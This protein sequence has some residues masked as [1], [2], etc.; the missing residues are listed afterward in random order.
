MAPPSVRVRDHRG[1]RDDPCDFRGYEV[2]TDDD[3]DDAVWAVGAGM[4]PP[5]APIQERHEVRGD[6]RP[7]Q[8][9]EESW[10][11]RATGGRQP[12][13]ALPGLPRRES[14]IPAPVADPPSLC[15]DV[16]QQGPHVPRWIGPDYC[17]QIRESG[18][19]MRDHAGEP[20]Q[21][22]GAAMRDHAGEPGRG[23]GAAKRDHAGE[24]GRGS[25]AAK[26]DHAG[27]PGRGSGAAKRDHAGEPGRGSGA[28]KRDHAGE[29]GRGSGAAKRDHAGEPGRG[30][31]AA[32]R[33]HAGEPGRGS[34]AA[35]RDHAGEP[36]RGSGAATPDHAGE[37]A[38]GTGAATPDHAGEPARGTGAAT[39]DHAGEPARGTGA[40]TP[41]HAG[42]PARGTGPPFVPGMPPPQVPASP[43]YVP[44]MPP[45][46][47]PASPPYVPG[48]P[49][50]QVPAS[51]PYVPGMPPPQVPASPPY[52]PVMPQVPAS[53]PFVPGM[54]PPQA[55]ASPPPAP[56][57]QGTVGQLQDSGSV[58][59]QLLGPVKELTWKY[60]EMPVE[61]TSPPVQFQLR[62]PVSV[63]SVA[64]TC[65]ENMV[66]VQV[67]KDLF[68]SGE[69]IRASDISLGGC[70]VT[71][72]DSVAQLLYFQ[73]YLQACGSQV[74][75]NDTLVYSFSLTYLPTAAS[76]T[77]API[78]RTSGAVIG[79]EC[80]YLRLHNVSSNALQPAWIPYAATKIAQELL[81]FSLKLMTEAFQRVL[82][83]RSHP[84]EASVKQYN[85][86]PLR[87]FVDSCQVT[88]YPYAV[89]LNFL[90]AHWLLL[91]LLPRTQ[92]F[93]LQFQLEAFRFQQGDTGSLY[94]TCVLKAT[95][96]ASPTD[97]EHK[98]C[99][100][101]GQKWAGAGGEDQ[102]CSCCDGTCGSRKAR[103]L[104]S[105]SGM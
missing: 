45:P 15:P 39:P 11:K 97:A 22:S 70:G 95:A 62:E 54:P 74:M 81:V 63:S 75:T 98:A 65:D 82:H 24:P 69:L 18:A 8:Q 55:P 92:D 16:P 105:V 57:P 83:G 29:P 104:T 72:E 6:P 101:V 12:A 80:H 27:E 88:P 99:S 42:E 102:L 94:I 61:P 76:N 40:A 25:G 34:G 96:A 13:T 89:Q 23:S 73:S 58:Q 46:Q 5:I 66:H 9:C 38:R 20:G 84:F 43:P 26:R 7:S 67:K 90:M 1:V 60:P 68:G 2:D 100:F 33:D 53:P 4:A 93:K 51:P 31:G 17:V 77:S 44:G 41:D 59:Q 56:L 87:V 30:S 32:K 78:V 91:S 79:I 3:Q 28:A 86:V 64:A 19:V 103:D 21:G 10:W 85:H 14:S 48:M 71:G 52:V 47:V 36:G 37:P 50:P 49:P 35:K